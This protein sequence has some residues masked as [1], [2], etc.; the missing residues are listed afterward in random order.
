VKVIDINFATVPLRNNTPYWLGYGV[1][2]LLLA[3]FTVYN[4]WALLAYS[5]SKAELESDYDKKKTRL[6]SLYA[7]SGRLQESIKKK[8]VAILNERASFTNKLL[9]NRRF[10]WTAL[11]NKLEEVQPYQVRLL[12]LRPII[13]PNSILIEARAVA[14]DLKA[15]WNFQ[16]NLQN[17]PSFRRVYPGGWMKNNELGETIFNIAFNYF[18]DGAPS[19]LLALP[20][21]SSGAGQFVEAPGPGGW[22]GSEGDEAGSP[23]DDEPAL[24]AEPPPPPPRPTPRAAQTPPPRQP[25]QPVQQPPNA[26]LKRDPAQSAGRGPVPSPTAPTAAPPAG[27]GDQMVAMPAQ[28]MGA[29]PGTPLGPAVR[30]R[31]PV[32]DLRNPPGAPGAPGAEQPTKK[33]TPTVPLNPDNGTEDGQ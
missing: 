20:P 13:Q 15:F 6:E 17:H 7:E 21:D 11:L 4:G 23:S 33:D 12:S 8:D 1:G 16:Q 32:R 18:P 27:I 24:P 14:K 22:D 5:K 30:S 25:V 3:V 26:P 9:D 29:A 19:S 28:P 10:S 2:A 31:R